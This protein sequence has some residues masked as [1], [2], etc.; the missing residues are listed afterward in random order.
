MA[1]LKGPGKTFKDPNELRRVGTQIG[2]QTGRGKCK[3]AWSCAH[4]PV[5]TDAD[6]FPRGGFL[7][8]KLKGPRTLLR[9]RPEI[10]DFQPDLGLKLGQSKP[11]I[12]G[13]APTDRHTTVPDESGPISACFDDDPKPLKCKISSAESSRRIPVA[14]YTGAGEHP[15]STNPSGLMRLSRGVDR[16]MP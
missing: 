14:T 1:E 16:S 10:C 12:S 4:K 6:R 2:P 3:N 13:T 5:Q 15:L 7:S 8:A 9:I 11:K